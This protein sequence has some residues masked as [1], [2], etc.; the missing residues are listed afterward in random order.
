MK[1]TINTIFKIILLIHVMHIQK[2]NKLTETNLIQS[3]NQLRITKTD[4]TTVDLIFTSTLQDIDKLIV[5]NV[6]F[7]NENI[8]NPKYGKC[9][10][11]RTCNCQDGFLNVDWEG[12]KT[13]C[14]YQQKKQVSAFLLEL[15]IMGAGQM[16]RGYIALGILKLL[17]VV[18]FPYILI[19]LNFL[20]FL[21]EASVKVQT[22]VLITTITLFFMYIAGV[23]F[24]YFYDVINFGMN[25]FRDWY[26]YP[27]QSW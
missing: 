15:F 19:A 1:F 7:C 9:L 25:R 2:S 26:G 4:T 3:K 8:C 27:L 21:A 18:I 24:W 17:Y 22:G 12:R 20:G 11:S 6:D 10:T 23:L 13:L 16:Y 14:D 5:A